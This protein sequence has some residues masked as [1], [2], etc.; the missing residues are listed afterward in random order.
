MLP[1]TRKISY[2]PDIM[3]HFFG[4]NILSSFF[5]DGADYTVPAINIKELEK[6]FEIEVAVPGLSKEDFSITLDKGLLTI[7]S[8]SKKENKEESDKYTRREFSFTSFRR[9]FNLPDNV[10]MEKIT[11]RHENGILN[12]VLPKIDEA[13]TKRSKTI[14]IS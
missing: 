5:S 6:G 10:D 8:E 13:K 9:S 11:A 2:V 7:S 3:D 4:N 12:I 14:K 1:A